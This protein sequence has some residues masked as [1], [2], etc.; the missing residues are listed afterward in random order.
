MAA[1]LAG[2]V[3]AGLVR[4]G[5]RQVAHRDHR[6]AKPF[7]GF[8]AGRDRLA[9]RAQDA[10]GRS[11][12]VDARWNRGGFANNMIQRVPILVIE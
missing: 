1:G 8:S 7:D 10:S 5:A 4:H 2:V 3:S 12:P 11:R 9:V 6:R